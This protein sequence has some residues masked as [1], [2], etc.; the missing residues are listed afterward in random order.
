MKTKHEMEL[1]AW[2]A[3]VLVIVGRPVVVRKMPNTSPG[4]GVDRTRIAIE[5]DPADS[6]VRVRRGPLDKGRV[7][8]G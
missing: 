7:R 4:D 3:A 1:S 2:Q 8:N 5:V 6:G